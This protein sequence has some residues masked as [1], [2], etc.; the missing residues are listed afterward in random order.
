MFQSEPDVNNNNNN[1]NNNND[2]DDEGA[3]VDVTCSNVCGEN[4]KTQGKT[5][6]LDGYHCLCDLNLDRRGD[7]LVRTGPR[8]R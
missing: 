7:K 5:P 6:N 2:D 4:G 8:S 1:N 3:D